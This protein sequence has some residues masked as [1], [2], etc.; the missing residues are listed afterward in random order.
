MLDSEAT[1]KLFNENEKYFFLSGKELLEPI[2]LKNSK[3][4]T[5]ITSFVNNS[6]I[7]LN[8]L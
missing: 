2:I 6:H 3:T 7:K 5:T 4:L 1:L 8:N